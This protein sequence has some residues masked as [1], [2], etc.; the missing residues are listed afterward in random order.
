MEFEIKSIEAN[1]NIK[2]VNIKRVDKLFALLLKR[3]LMAKPIM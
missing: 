3:E 2:D 1:R